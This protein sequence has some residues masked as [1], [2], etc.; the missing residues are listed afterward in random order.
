VKRV[1]GKW[2]RAIGT[3]A[4][5]ADR[6][7]ANGGD[8]TRGALVRRSVLVVP[9][10]VESGDEVRGRNDGCAG[11][12]HHLDHAGGYAIQIRHGVALRIFHRQLFA[13]RKPAE[14]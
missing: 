2:S 9:D 10:R 14:E 11:V 3:T 4:G 13:L 1:L 5:K 12:A 8:C 7:L 6:F